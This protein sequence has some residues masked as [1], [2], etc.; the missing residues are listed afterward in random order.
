MSTIATDSNLPLPPV[1][2][3]VEIDPNVD[4]GVEIDPNVDP[5]LDSGLPDPNASAPPDPGPVAD[6]GPPSGLP[7]PPNPPVGGDPGMPIPPPPPPQ[8]DL[9]VTMG[10]GAGGT[11]QLPGTQGAVPFRTPNFANNRMVGDSSGMGGA[12]GPTGP[13]VPMHGGFGNAEEAYPEDLLNRIV[14]GR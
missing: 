3:G 9:P 6:P 8:T 7:G 12:V 1:D 4:P 10:G 11:F 2:P 13:G 14:L 5:A